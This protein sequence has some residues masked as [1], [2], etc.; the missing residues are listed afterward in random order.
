MSN[1]HHHRKRYNQKDSSESRPIVNGTGIERAESITSTTSI[2][3]R[4]KNTNYS[5]STRYQ[6][7]TSTSPTTRKVSRDFAHIFIIQYPYETRTRG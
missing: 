4:Q 1:E 7:K 3:K 5:T 2:A 6:P